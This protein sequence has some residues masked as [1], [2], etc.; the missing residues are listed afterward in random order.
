MLPRLIVAMP[1]GAAQVSSTVPAMYGLVAPLAVFPGHQHGGGIYRRAQHAAE[2]RGN[3]WPHIEPS[4][5][6]RNAD[7]LMLR[8]V[9]QFQTRQT[10]QSRHPLTG[11]GSI[12]PDFTRDGILRTTPA[13]FPTI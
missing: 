5:V 9:R 8:R 3:R 7:G 13:A 10:A 4:N 11:F 6:R 12:V 2:R 1:R